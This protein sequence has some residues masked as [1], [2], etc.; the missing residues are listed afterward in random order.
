MKRFFVTLL[1]MF[2]LTAPFAFAQD[3]GVLNSITD[4]GY[5]SFYN[6]RSFKAAAGARAGYQRLAVSFNVPAPNTFSGFSSRFNFETM[7]MSLKDAGVWTGS[8][9][10]DL[11]IGPLTLGGEVFGSARRDATVNMDFSGDVTTEP[12]LPYDSPWTWDAKQ[13]QWMA[14]DVTARLALRNAYYVIGGY[15]WDKLEFDLRNPRNFRGPISGLVIYDTERRFGDITANL[16]IPYFG[17]GGEHGSFNWKLVGS[18]FATSRTQTPIRWITTFQGAT[19]LSDSRYSLTINRGRYLEGFA[20]YIYNPGSPVK[21]SVWTKGS[22][23]ANRGAG[24]LT[25]DAKLQDVIIFGTSGAID[26]D[27]SAFTRYT[28]GGGI[29]LEV[30]Y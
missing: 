15:R 17:L 12:P 4:S 29:G 7:D 18:W 30:S 3:M 16:W 22:Y 14:A 27:D 25:S 19:D 5:S 10:V 21:F 28:Y 26:V 8:A 13:L 20:E 1:L 6:Y 11:G 24:Q 2:C 23:F 9:F